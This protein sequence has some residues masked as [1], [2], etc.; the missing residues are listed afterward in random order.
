MEAAPMG[1]NDWAYAARDGRHAESRPLQ[2]VAGDE[3]RLQ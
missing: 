1:N 2:S 3:A